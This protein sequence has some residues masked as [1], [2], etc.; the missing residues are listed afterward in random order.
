MDPVADNMVKYT[1]DKIYDIYNV[2]TKSLP[3]ELK[4]ND[5]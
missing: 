2:T 3:I 5:L 1:E 4:E